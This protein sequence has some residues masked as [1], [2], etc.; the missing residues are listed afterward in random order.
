[1][2]KIITKTELAE[3]KDAKS[4]WIAIHDKIYD[5]TK[6]L[7]EHPGGE[8]VLLEQ[9]GRNATEAFEDV[10][11]STD[12]RDL[13]QQYEIGELP[14]N[15]REAKTT[16]KSLTPNAPESAGEGGWSSWL[17]PLGI[18]VAAALVYRF[19]IAPTSS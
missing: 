14:E 5:I 19:I 8:E 11:H 15:E 18:A 7:E 9:G 13:M 6:F 16:K 10:G 4:I 2:P 17:L 1:M 12:A 3:H